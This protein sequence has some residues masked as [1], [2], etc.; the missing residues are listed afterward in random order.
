MS[1]DELTDSITLEDVT[2][3][4]GSA[5]GAQQAALIVAG[6][7]VASSGGGQVAELAELAE[8]TTGAA[9]GALKEA[10][11]IPIALALGGAGDAV[12]SA[13]EEVLDET[14]DS[15]EQVE[16]EGGGAEGG[17]GDAGREGG[18]QEVAAAKTMAGAD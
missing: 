11:A 13:A 1:V 10:Q 12:S 18:V 3:A 17:D 6:I 14:G 8:L 4:I 5:D 7:A 9:M 15:E 16:E 2:D